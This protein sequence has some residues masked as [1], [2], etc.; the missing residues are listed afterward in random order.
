MFEGHFLVV[1]PSLIIGNNMNNPLHIKATM[2]IILISLF[3][4]EIINENQ[5]AHYPH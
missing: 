5:L 3:S 4:M 1:P 2:N